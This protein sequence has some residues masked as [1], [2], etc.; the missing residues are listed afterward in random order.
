MPVMDEF[1]EEREALKHGTPKQKLDYFLD[2]YKWPTIA[3]IAIFIFAASL[4]YHVV[5]NKPSAFYGVFINC[6]TTDELSESFTQEFADA[7]GINLKKN[8]VTIDSSLSLTKSAQDQA[9]Y[10]TVQKM[11]VYLAAKEIDVLASDVSSFN[12]Y[13]YLNTIADL[14]DVLTPEQQALYEPYYFYV[15]RKVIEEQSEAAENLEES[16]V[17]YPDPDKP[18]EMEDPV[19]V[20]LYLTDCDKLDGN[21]AFTQTPVV[22]GIIV[23]ST[24]TETAVQFLDYLFQ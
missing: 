11:A 9:S 1:R 18:E 22:I 13:A 17:E 12:R 23:N 24:H 15:D 6:L 4:I 19:P 5:T 14:R 16:P 8:N 7:A 21:F 2:Y 10:V 3:G 20:G